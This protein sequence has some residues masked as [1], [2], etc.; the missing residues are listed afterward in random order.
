MPLFFIEM[1]QGLVG[2]GNDLRIKTSALYSCTFIA[3]YNKDTQRGGAF[4][5]PSESINSSEVLEAMNQW[6]RELQPNEA[7]VV[8][9]VTAASFG[10]ST[11]GAPPQDIID[12]KNWVAQYC[13]V[14]P[15]LTSAVGAGMAI[16]ESSLQAGSILNLDGDFEP[17]GDYTDV[18]WRSAGKL[19]DH[20]E[21]TLFGYNMESRR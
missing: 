13:K 14:A 4:H 7:A 15:T 12:L 2:P 11:G 16:V 20:P 10:M 19:A 1:G 18:S 6:M 3:A 9:L 5:Y 21:F 17:D 8:T